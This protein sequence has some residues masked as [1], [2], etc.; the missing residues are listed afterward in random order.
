MNNIHSAI[1]LVI[2]LGGNIHLPKTSKKMHGDQ[3]QAELLRL[4]FAKPSLRRQNQ[5]KSY[6]FRA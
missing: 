5:M 4:G 2:P 1:P 3:N 6:L